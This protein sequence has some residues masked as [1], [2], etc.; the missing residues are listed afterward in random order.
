VPIFHVI[1]RQAG[2]RFDPA[3]PLEQQSGWAAHAAYMNSLVEKGHI[4]LGGPLPNGRVAHAMEAES[5]QELR[6]LWARDPWYE[7]HLILD[8]VEPWE[9]RLDRRDTV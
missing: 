1:L 2:P 7:S 8:S 5:E 4:V 6:A 3:L 9:I